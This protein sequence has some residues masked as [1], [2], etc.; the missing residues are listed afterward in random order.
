[1]SPAADR[2]P[3][4]A[5]RWRPR[6]RRSPRDRRCGSRQPLAP[7][8][9]LAQ[10]EICEQIRGFAEAQALLRAEP[11]KT[12]ADQRIAEQAQSTVLQFLVEID[13]HVAAGDEMHLGE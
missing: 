12:A 4:A 2:A 7:V 5:P 1:M 8:D 3:G 11:E 10:G 13:E 6:N 9:A